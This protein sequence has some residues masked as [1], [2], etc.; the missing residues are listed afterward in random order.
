[1]STNPYATYEARYAEL[2]AKRDAVNKLTAP[3]QLKLDA[4]NARAQKAQAEANALAL[5][6]QEKRGNGAWIA[7]K[8]EIGILATIL[9]KAAK[10]A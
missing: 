10:S 7:L 1:M 3:L 8:K 5:E 6:I 4:A 2:T 9:T